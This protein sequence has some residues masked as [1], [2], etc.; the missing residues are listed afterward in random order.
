MKNAEISKW[1]IYN[2]KV[3]DG[4]WNICQNVGKNAIDDIVKWH[5]DVDKKTLEPKTHSNYDSLHML[6]RNR[7]MSFYPNGVALDFIYDNENLTHEKMESDLVVMMER[8]M[9]SVEDGEISFKNFIDGAKPIPCDDAALRN[10]GI[11]DY[12]TNGRNS[13]LMHALIDYGRLTVSQDEAGIAMIKPSF[14]PFN[15]TGL[16]RSIRFNLTD[17][18]YE[19]FYGLTTGF[20]ITIAGEKVG[21]YYNPND[22]GVYEAIDNAKSTMSQMIG[23]MESEIK[24]SK[25]KLLT[26][27]HLK[28]AFGCVDNFA[29]CGGGSLLFNNE[30]W[31][32]KS[33]RN[34]PKKISDNLFLCDLY[35][36]DDMTGFPKDIGNLILKR[37][38][39]NDG[40]KIP[41][42]IHVRGD[43]RII[44]MDPRIL[45]M[46]ARS[47]MKIDGTIVSEHYSGSKEHLNELIDKYGWDDGQH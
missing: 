39:I 4:L 13:Y 41:K 36:L 46:I 28:Y 25:Y 38:R 44:N 8:N 24:K 40:M 20:G 7:F 47:D 31:K 33:C 19:P 35:D 27:G 22:Q 43:I 12:N 5:I 21:D 45:I 42:G 23:Y 9:L 3:W 32:L 17:N 10:E 30:G 11:I 26:R 34:F 18:M 29:L 37:I 6:E 16:K 2:N 1:L 15:K 14:M